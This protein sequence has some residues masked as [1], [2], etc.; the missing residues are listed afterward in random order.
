M[1]DPMLLFVGVAVTGTVTARVVLDMAGY[2]TESADLWERVLDRVAPADTA[3][4]IS[5]DTTRRMILRATAYAALVGCVAWLIGMPS[6]AF[7]VAAFFAAFVPPACRELR[8]AWQ[9]RIDQTAS[10]EGGA[11]D[12]EGDLSAEAEIDK[13]DLGDGAIPETS[14]I[15]SWITCSVTRSLGTAKVHA[16]MTALRNGINRGAFCAATGKPQG[17]YPAF[18][19]NWFDMGMLERSGGRCVLTY[20]GRVKVAQILDD[21]EAM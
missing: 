18:L 12:D 11:V 15:P 2:G 4:S 7:G 16:L 21:I 8:V 6:I 20:Q 13:D 17:E 19:Q 10:T 14:V 1:N 3:P 9:Y 5:P